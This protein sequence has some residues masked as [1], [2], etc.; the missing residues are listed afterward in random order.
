[1]VVMAMTDMG[2]IRNSNPHLDRADARMSLFVARSGPGSRN[3]GQMQM[4]SHLTV[5]YL[6]LE[7]NTMRKDKDLLM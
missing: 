6:A 5:F 2:R 4:K 7:T 3:A 1:M